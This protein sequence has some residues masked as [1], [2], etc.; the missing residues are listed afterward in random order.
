MTAPP[1]LPT[2]GSALRWARA[3]GVDRLD[4]QGL[5]AHALQRDRSWVLAHDDDTLTTDQRQHVGALLTRRAAGEPYAYLV[6]TREFRGLP[7]QVTPDVLIPRPDTESLVEWALECLEGPLR[8]VAAP[9]VADLGTGS[10]AI[11]L[12]LK[13][14]CPRARLT[15]TDCS[16]AALA[17]ASANAE[18]LRLAVDW[19]AGRWWGALE[20]AATRRWHL[21]VSNPPYVA[22]GDPHLAAL[23][24]E[25]A[26][27]LVPADDTGDGLADLARIAEGAPRFLVPGGWLLLEHGADQGAAVRELLRRHG[28]REV[29]TRRDLGGQE[30][31]TGGALPGP[32]G[33]N[34]TPGTP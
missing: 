31:V 26:G 17:I 25:P 27:A 15:G 28:L 23:V 4:A 5:V 16:P 1:E 24:H 11:A 32:V 34:S 19:R 3:R 22:P 6:G 20:S 30:R 2:V 33:N 13:H 21:A 14:A 12:A 18:R 29:T 8:G 7:L 9:A 10:G